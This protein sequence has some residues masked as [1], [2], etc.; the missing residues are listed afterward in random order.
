MLNAGINASHG[1]PVLIV[2]PSLD[3]LTEV[4]I[5]TSNYGAMYGKSASGTVMA[6]TKSGTQSFHGNL[7][8]FLRNE[9]PERPK[10]F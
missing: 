8:E 4:K 1:S 9:D 3:A 7:Y 10:L 6:T 2:Y 5:L